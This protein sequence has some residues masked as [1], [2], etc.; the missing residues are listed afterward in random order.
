RHLSS[1]RP[2]AAATDPLSLHD[3]LP[4]SNAA[5]HPPPRTGRHNGNQYPPGCWFSFYPAFALSRWSPSPEAVMN[6]VDPNGPSLVNIASNPLPEG[7]RGGYFKT[8]Y[9][10]LLRVAFWPMSAVQSSGTSC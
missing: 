4:I 9:N 2:P 8:A 5:R 10:V 1:T 7:A 6:I 3:A